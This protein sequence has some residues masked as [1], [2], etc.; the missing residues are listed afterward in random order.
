VLLSQDAIRFSRIN[1]GTRRR[2]KEMKYAVAMRSNLPELGGGFGW[3]H[4]ARYFL[5]AP[6]SLIA[7]YRPRLSSDE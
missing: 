4:H 2:V 5:Q 3:D 6:Q 7:G 1:F